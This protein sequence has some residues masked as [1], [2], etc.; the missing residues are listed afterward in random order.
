MFLGSAELAAVCALLG[1]IP[2]TDEYLEIA[3]KKVS[4]LANEIY[5]Y[6][7][8]DEIP[9]FIED[10]RVITQQEESSIFQTSNLFE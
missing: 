1:H 9:N 3:S 10:G 6:L 7:N 8:F 5:R 2:T 4:P